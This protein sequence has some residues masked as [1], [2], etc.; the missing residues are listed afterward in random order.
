MKTLKKYLL[1]H[2]QRHNNLKEQYSLLTTII[3]IGDDTA[4]RVLAGIGSIEHAEWLE[5]Y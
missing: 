5:R 2:I 1:R 3:E 4:A